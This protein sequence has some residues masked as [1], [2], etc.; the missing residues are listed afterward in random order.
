MNLFEFLSPVLVALVEFVLGF[1][2][3]AERLSRLVVL[4]AEEKHDDVCVLLD[5]TRFTQVSEYRPLAL[6]L[7]DGTRQLRERKYGHIELLGERLQ[8]PRDVGHLLDPV[9]DD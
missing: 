7:L 9:F 5:R 1:L 6:A 3:A 4:L 2:E 8:P